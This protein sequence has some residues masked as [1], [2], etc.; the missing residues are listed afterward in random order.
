MAAFTKNLELDAGADEDFD[1]IWKIGPS[2]SEVPVD[3]TGCTAKLQVRAKIGTAVLVELTTENGGIVL[4]AS[5]EI[6]LHF[7]DTHTAALPAKAIYQME[8]TLANGK[9]RRLL[10]GYIVTSAEL[11]QP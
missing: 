8:V 6:E 2:G 7:T 5:G 10:K 9:V 1:F 4:G 11:V 3:M